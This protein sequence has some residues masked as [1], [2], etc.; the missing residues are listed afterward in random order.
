[1]GQ[2]EVSGAGA[3]PFL[4]RLLTNDILKLVPGQGQYTLMCNPLGG[5]I[6]DLYAYCLPNQQYLLIVNASRIAEDFDWIE[7]HRSGDVRLENI[8]AGSGA[9]AVQGPAVSAFIDRCFPNRPIAGTVVESPNGLRKNHAAQFPLDGATFWVARTGY[10]GE[11]GFEI[12]TSAE[13]LEGI[14]QRVMQIGQSAGIKPAGLGARDTL[15]TE[16]CF[17]LYGHE[18]ASE[19]TPIEAGLKFFVSLEKGDFIGREVLGRQAREGSPRKLIAFK[20]RDKS[21]PPRPHYAILSSGPEQQKLGEVTSG[22]QSPTLGIG[23]GMGYVATGSAQPGTLLNI[24]IRGRPAAAEIVK[25][26]L[27]KKPITEP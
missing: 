26:P 15:R 8:S 2:I 14:W 18:L 27:Y 20:M 5:V 13:A 11:D 23:I 7:S 1:M 4:N 9:I 25:K 16:A 10:T 6:D 3:A 12:F 19:T 22:T 24:E 21:A 17:P